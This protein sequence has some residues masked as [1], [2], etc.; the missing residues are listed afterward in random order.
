[1]E[2]STNTLARLA[3]ITLG[4]IALVPLALVLNGWA[5]TKLWSWFIVP[6]FGLPTLTI[7]YAIGLCCVVAL[8]THKPDR[9]KSDDTKALAAV[10]AV[11]AAPLMSVLLGWIVKS[12][13]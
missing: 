4:A 8:I 6:Q 12:F 2:K 10:V 3:L 5:V 11:F 1:M 9:S 13:I 7:P